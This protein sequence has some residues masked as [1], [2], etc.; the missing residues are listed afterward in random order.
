MSSIGSFLEGEY[1]L[2]GPPLAPRRRRIRP[3]LREGVSGEAVLLREG[4]GLVLE[5][6][7]EHAEEVGLA[8]ITEREIEKPVMMRHQVITGLNFATQLAKHP[9]QL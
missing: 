3:V 4:R 9:N 7:P 2:G 6:G 5:T 8:L 1:V